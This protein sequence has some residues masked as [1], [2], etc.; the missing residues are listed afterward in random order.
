MTKKIFIGKIV[1]RVQGTVVNQDGEPLIGVN[2]QGKDSSKGTATD[3]EGKFVLED[4]DENAVLVIS[5]VGYQTQEIPIAGNS[6]LYI[7][8]LSDSEML[9]DV[10]LGGYGTLMNL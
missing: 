9:D 1:F 5:Y 8:L 6:E 3:F 2:I 10:V 4:V 7:V